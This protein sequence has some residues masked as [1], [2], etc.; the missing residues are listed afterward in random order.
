MLPVHERGSMQDDNERIKGFPF[1]HDHSSMSK[2]I[3]YPF[4]VLVPFSL[5]PEMMRLGHWAFWLSIPTATI[6][7]LVFIIMEEVGDYNENPFMGIPNCMPLLA[8]CR[9]IEIDLREM[10]GEQDVPKPIPPVNGVLM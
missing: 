3:V 10:P 1:P 2:L 9:T 8:L 6:I 4:I 7:G 5:V